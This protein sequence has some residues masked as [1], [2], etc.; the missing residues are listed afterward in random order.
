[1]PHIIRGPRMQRSDSA[2]LLTLG[3]GE[4]AL[5]VDSTTHERGFVVKMINRTG[6]VSVKG[7]L[8]SPSTTADREVIKQANEYDT[9]GVVQQAGVAEGAEMWVWTVGSVCQV[10]FKDTVAATRG[11]ILLASDTDGRAIDA[12]NPGIGLPGT[13][14][15]F[16]ECGQVMES[17]EAGTDVLALASLHFN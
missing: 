17:K 6:G 10:L 16:K 15:H 3:D 7:T 5:C 11:N 1:M 4:A 2:Q 14:T 13:E 12:Q 9:I 8:V